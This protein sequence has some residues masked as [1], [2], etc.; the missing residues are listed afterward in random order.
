MDS[1]VRASWEATVPA[2][3]GRTIAFAA[4]GYQERRRQGHAHAPRGSST[5]LALRRCDSAA[6]TRSAD[7]TFELSAAM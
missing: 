3:P 4:E 7:C 1:R 2:S 6:F 5:S